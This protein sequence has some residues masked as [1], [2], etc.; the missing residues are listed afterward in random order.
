MKT[1][2]II[3]EYNPLHYGH[4]FLM[5]AVRRQYG[6]DTA[7]ICAMS[8]DFV[9]R[10][11]FALVRRQA[12]AEAAVRSG[13]DLVLELPLPWAV[14]SAEGFARGGIDVLTGT[15]MLDVLA[16]G[17]ECGDSAALLRAAKALESPALPPLLK[18]ALAQ[19]D[20]FAAAR[21]RAV[22]ALLAAEDAAL[23]SSPNNT[24][25]IEY[26]RVLLQSGSEPEIFTVSR[27]GAAHDAAAGDALS[28]MVPA[29][30][31]AYAAEEAAGR[32]PVFASACERAILSRL[33]GMSPADF[34]A[35]DTG[36]EGIGQRL[37]NASREASS[38]SAILDAAKTR[39]YAYAR[40][41]RM[42][43]WAYLGL[44]PADVPAHVPY[45][46]VL[47][48]NETGRTLLHQMRKRTQLPVITKPAAVRQ[49]S[50]E[51]QALF[52][53]EA[54]GA[55]LYALAY[56]ALSAAAGGTL[57]RQGPAML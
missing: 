44:T 56:P 10:G 13:A 51:A 32:A 25:G 16:F 9:Q 50:P 6:G 22:S 27:T 43:L 53:L 1:A 41:R 19:G 55:D 4:A 7:I 23:L 47:A 29:M 2:G 24:L 33:R 14:S 3:T 48:A 20:S 46:R 17:S 34:D 37:Y 38:L 8:G 35:L 21:Q 5:Q 11:D 31:A 49:L 52:R 12:R 28:R 26:C 30:Q 40:L 39:R 42:V 36:R 18:A 15:G 45:L 54:R 57:W